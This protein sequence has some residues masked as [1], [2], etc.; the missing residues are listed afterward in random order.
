MNLACPLCANTAAATV[1]E[2]ETC[3]WHRGL[4]AFQLST[5]HKF[6]N[7]LRVRDGATGSVLN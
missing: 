1:G 3:I 4:E 2:I 7:D 5:N 6:G